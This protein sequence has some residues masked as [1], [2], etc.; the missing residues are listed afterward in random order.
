MFRV[1][2]LPGVSCRAWLFFVSVSFF[3]LQAVLVLPVEVSFVYMLNR[4][5]FVPSYTSPQ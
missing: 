1:L 3:F 2:K 5:C 4:K